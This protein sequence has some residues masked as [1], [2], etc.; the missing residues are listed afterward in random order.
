M[1]RHIEMQHFA[2][3]MFQHEQHL[4][5][6]RGHGEEVHRDHTTKVVVQEGLPGLAGLSRQLPQKSGDG[7]FRDLDAKH[8]QLAV[9]PR[10]AP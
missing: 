5:R 2:T 6:D 4:H 8:L 10:G 3:A 1:L 9:N 7:P